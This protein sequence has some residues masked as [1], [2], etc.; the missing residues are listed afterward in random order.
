[1]RHYEI[2]FLIHAD[3]S[4]Q[5]PAM[6]DKYRAVVKKHKGKIS[7]VEDWGRRS[8][9]YH[10]NRVHKAHY[11]L[12]NIEG[13]AETIKELQD[14]FDYND[15]ILRHLIIR[16]SVAETKPSIMMEV[17]RQERKREVEHGKTQDSTERKKAYNE[18]SNVKSAESPK[19]EAP[20]TPKTKDIEERADA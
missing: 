17:I 5:V 11:V 13:D 10:I 8:L 16:M 9:A 7:R 20:A 12:M 3:Q 19:T 1:M 4:D 2:I 15:A 6:I 14:A 18:S